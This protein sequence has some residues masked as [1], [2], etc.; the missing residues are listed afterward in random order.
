M[1]F[2]KDKGDGYYQYA[3]DAA[4]ESYAHLTPTAQQF[5]LH[6]TPA[7][8][9]NA[10]ILAQMAILEHKILCALCDKDPEYAAL[11]ATLK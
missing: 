10:P 5:P 2:F 6:P 3:D 9:H 4:P 7:A 8:I 1:L 11:K